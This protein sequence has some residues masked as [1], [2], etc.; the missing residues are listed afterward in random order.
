MALEAV[1]PADRSRPNERRERP[2][3]GGRARANEPPVPLDADDD[4][5]HAAFG[6]GSVGAL[7]VVAAEEKAGFRSPD[8]AVDDEATSTR[9]FR[10]DDGAE[11]HRGAEDRRDGHDVPA[12]KGGMHA[13]ALHREGDRDAT[14]RQ[15]AEEIRALPA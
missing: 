6:N 5:E 12:A 14:R 2:P 7:G 3:E 10:R 1:Q 11:R 15:L 4:A 8:D 9:G 13:R